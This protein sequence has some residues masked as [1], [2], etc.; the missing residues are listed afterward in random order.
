M[1]ANA[2]SRRVLLAADD[3]ERPLLRSLLHGGA[4]HS[5]DVTEA[6]SFEQA[7]FLVQMDACDV[8]LLDASLLVSGDP[9]GVSWLAARLEAPVLFLAEPMPEVLRGAGTAGGYCLL[10]RSL[11][12]SQP[13]LLHAALLQ[14]SRLADLRRDLWQAGEQLR[15]CRQRIDRLLGRLWECSPTAGCRHWFSQRYMLERLQEEVSRA[16]RHGGPLTVVLGE[17]LPR[18]GRLE[19]AEVQQLAV[20]TAECI[21]RTK[22]RSDVA[23][24]WGPTSFMLLLPRTSDTSASGA[25]HRLRGVLEEG[26]SP[27]AEPHPPLI[28]RFGLAAFTADIA[29]PQRLLSR[30]EE[31]LE[32]ARATNAPIG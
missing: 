22:R 2:T 32:R 20:W 18:E 31:S 27:L 12:L 21:S 26:P 28:A 7:R 6:G 29:S 15:D 10:P 16:H 5:W 17:L 23:G 25:C 14:A 4:W 13:I 8:L 11:A 3:Q 30:A 19:P 1:H 24:Q 9:G